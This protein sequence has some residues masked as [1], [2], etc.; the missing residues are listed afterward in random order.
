MRVPALSGPVELLHGS[1][2]L[3]LSAEEAAL[4]AQLRQFAGDVMRPIGTQADAASAEVNAGPTSP[5]RSYFEQFRA[6]GVDVDAIYLGDARHG[7]RLKSIAFEA[8]GWGDGGLA[9]GT[10][11]AHFPYVMAR[12]LGRDDL[13]DMARGRIGCWIA[14]QMSRGSDVA[15]VEGTEIAPGTRNNDPELSAYFDGNE[16]VL[17]GRSSDWVSL[18]PIADVAVCYAVFTENGKV[19]WRPNGSA[20]GIGLIIDLSEH[21][22]SKGAAFAKLGQ[23]A[24]PQGAIIFDNVRLPR[25]AVIAEPDGYDAS[26]LTALIEGNLTMATVWTGVAQ[27]A[28]DVMADWAHGR[29]QGGLTIAQHQLVKY[30]LFDAYRQVEASR[31]LSRSAFAHAALA[32]DPHLLPGILAKVTATQTAVAVAGEAVSLYGAR[33]LVGG[34]LADR[35]FRDARASL[36]EDGDN[37]VLGLKAGTYLS[38]AFLGQSCSDLQGIA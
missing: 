19:V 10:M 7:N 36:V 17:K 4:A 24:L 11:V 28:Y 8:L 20:A 3:G 13:A 32:K 30:R 37:H 34:N 29:R 16:V 38:E 6:L 33:G 27:A 23:R 9:I 2:D 35:L 5:F 31:A 25:S 1:I 22:I 26:M 12:L 14:T 21:G 15:D 18:G